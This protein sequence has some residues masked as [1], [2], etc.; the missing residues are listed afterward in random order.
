MRLSIPG[1]YVLL[2]KWHLCF[3]RRFSLFLF[4]FL[5]HLLGIILRQCRSIGRRE[6]G[7]Q[8]TL[9]DESFRELGNLIIVLYPTR[10]L[11]GPDE[12]WF[13]LLSSRYYDHVAPI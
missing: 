10:S 4:L 7:A 3:F 1:L 8:Y 12:F 9:F 13:F 11:S 5:F 2:L 6:S